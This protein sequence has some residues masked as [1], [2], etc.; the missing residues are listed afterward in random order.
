MQLL[1]VPNWSFGRDND[2]L[3]IFEDLLSSRDLKVHFC[4]RDVDHNRTVTA[5]SGEAEVVFERLERLAE[6][7]FERIDLQRH[8][9]VHPRIGALDVCPFVRLDNEVYPLKAKIEAFGEGLSK[10][11]DLPIFLYEKSERGK[12][13]D[14]LPQL[15][16]AGFGG[17]MLM[18][19]ID[20]DFG[21]RKVHPRLGATIMGER[22]FLIA[23]NVN[24][25]GVDQLPL[26]KE[27]AKMIRVKREAGDPLFAGVRA[28][29]LPL[30][31]RDMA[32]ISMNMTHPNI[33]SP[34]EII[35]KILFITRSS[36]ATHVGNELIG[37][38]RKR[39]LAKSTWLKI[40]PNQIVPL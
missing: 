17:L 8:I 3:R 20:A 32:Q 39:D 24:L 40:E 28:L 10:K 18:P 21:P 22:D 33:T 9:G 6:A 16:K 12:H 25:K 36:N 4:K 30:I 11:F 13:S 26:A 29:G 19:E 34:D 2:L 15:R 38:I 27:I 37:V 1:T 5:F 31:S 23:L 14:A 7:A 35:N